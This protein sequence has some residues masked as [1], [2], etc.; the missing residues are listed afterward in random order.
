MVSGRQGMNGRVVART[1]RVSP[2]VATNLTTVAASASGGPER[3][4]GYIAMEEARTIECRSGR[5]QREPG[6]ASGPLRAGEAAELD[7]RF[8]LLRWQMKGRASG[9]VE[10][11]RA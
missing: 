11:I 7:A 4:P 8:P 10:K 3:I 5:G 9:L 6:R 1:F 2:T